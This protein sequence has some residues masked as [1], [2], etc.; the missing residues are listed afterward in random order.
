MRGCPHPLTCTR[1]AL[2]PSYLSLFE[3]ET[4]AGDGDIFGRNLVIL[5][6]FA[7]QSPRSRLLL[8]G[9]EVHPERLGQLVR[10][11]PLHGFTSQV[12]RAGGLLSN[13]VGL[14]L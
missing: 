13:T 5:R 4:Q 8:G 10:I 11:H 12:I 9:G 14:R 7:T 6:T 1:Q 2:R 3:V